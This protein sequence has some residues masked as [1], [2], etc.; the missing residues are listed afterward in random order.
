MPELSKK[1]SQLRGSIMIVAGTT[2]GGGML[3]LPMTSA[4]LEF[5]E[6][7]FFMMFF[8]VLMV[9]TGFLQADVHK[10]SQK[11]LSIAT[12][13]GAILGPWA[14]RLASI[15]LLLLFHALLAAYAT[16]AS[17]IIKNH[18]DSFFGAHHGTFNFLYPSLYVILC[19]FSISYRVKWLDYTNRFFFLLKLVA[20]LIL[21]GSLLPHVQSSYFF[22]KEPVCCCDSLAPLWPYISLAIPIFFTSFGFHG[23]IPSLFSYMDN[24]VKNLKKAIFWGS[25]IPL[26]VYILWQSMTLG[27]LDHNPE[28]LS[29]LAKTGD[30]SLFTQELTAHS[31]LPFFQT[32]ISLFAF[33]AITT[34]FLGV[35]L[36]LLDYTKEQFSGKS[37]VLLTFLP[38]VIMAC[39][40]PKGFLTCL[41]YA[42]IFL[43]I[44]AVILP[45]ALFLKSTVLGS[46]A[47][48][49]L[50][51]LGA[52]FALIVGIGLII[53][54]LFHVF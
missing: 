8:W 45:P 19:A 54:E 39:F 33:L 6:A 53:L 11:S 4:P 25:L 47:L 36:G 46:I 43:S 42:A 16:G 1:K 7:T 22:P 15:S 29:K 13:S 32:L 24:D 26:I 37:S 9:F 14:K 21:L 34:S 17:Q 5:V 10:H 35:G 12:L 52:I 31:T 30:L 38:S 49:P 40:Y 41:R 18:A 44:L 23:S 20:F 27:V 51:I 3:A 28:L 48:H 2:I 50:K